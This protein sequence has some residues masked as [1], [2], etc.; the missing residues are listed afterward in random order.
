MSKN[1]PFQ[2]LLIL[3][4]ALGV[5]SGHKTGLNHLIIAEII[6]VAGGLI[7]LML[8]K[9]KL[10]IGWALSFA[11][12]SFYLNL[13]SYLAPKQF[14]PGCQ[15]A[16]ISSQIK[17]SATYSEFLVSAKTGEAAV[18]RTKILGNYGY[19][20]KIELCATE[21][22]LT[23]E[24]SRADYFLA[25]YK[26][27][28]LIY[29]PDIKLLSE[30]KGFVR[31]VFNFSQ[32][33]ADAAKELFAGDTAVLAKGLIIGSSSG[34]SDRFKDNL[35]GSGTS[36]IVAVSGYNVSIITVII[37]QL[38]R[39]LFSRRSAIISS[40][41]F[42]AGFC[43]LSGF[44][45]SVT[46]ASF[47]GGVYILSKIIGR[48][49]TAINSLFV[50]GLVMLLVNPY[51]LWDISFE[52]S[53]AATAGL[54][55]SDE[56]MGFIKKK[57]LFATLL[58]ILAETLVAQIFTLPIIL[59]YFGRVSLVAPLANILI[60]PIIPLAMLFV[61]LAIA[62]FFVLKP[63][64]IIIGGLTSV[65]LNYVMLVI[66]GLGSL[67][68]SSYGFDKIHWGWT[69]AAYILLIAVSIIIREKIRS[70]RLQH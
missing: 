11:L 69:I 4:F 23:K 70:K 65:I 14:L 7:L 30:G 18:I 16:Q 1:L 61:S 46:R 5:I 6:L 56:I 15:S 3:C 31:A 47:M 17:E 29:N 57:V 33:I 62:A 32:K 63:L 20:D 45:P 50:A 37:F 60:L 66:N 24:T 64:G 13:H 22:N 39:N 53:F 34:F 67:R 2:T 43:L 27:T 19:A 9:Q 21:Q 12:G 36:H 28:N 42:L 58:T 52:L 51:T 40:I 48:K 25:K 26:T 41:L 44:T 55:F 35:Q 8:K 54:A 59:L 68:W 10:V 49:G 38:I